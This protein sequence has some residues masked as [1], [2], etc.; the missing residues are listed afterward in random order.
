MNSHPKAR[1]GLAG[2]NALV[3]EIERG[4]SIRGA[5]RAFKVSP[6]TAHKWWHRRLR[7]EGL[8]DRSSRPH[9]SPRMLSAAAQE[10]ICEVRRNTGWG[11]RLVA[12]VVGRPHSTVHRTL[13]RH[14]ISRWSRPKREKAFRYEWPCP[15]DL[16]HM[17]TKRYARFSRPGHAVTG[18][19]FRSGAE[20]RAGVGY[21]WVH[22]IVDDHSRLAY[23]ELH[24]D[25]RAA[26]V[27]AFTRRALAFFEARGVRAKRL[28]TD[29][30]FAYTKS[31]ELRELLRA[32][33]IKHLLIQPRR[34]QTNGKVERFQ[35]TMA[36][37]WGYGLA[38][39]SSD[40]RARALSHWLR[41]YNESRPHSSIGDRP[42]ISRVHDLSR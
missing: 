13:Q 18:D 36:R 35:Q 15:G 40:H 32:R 24:P 12:G 42:P 21:E 16:L 20:K 33:E 28:M 41:Y 23:S 26:T 9:R 29:N 25:E 7:G 38:Y 1:L 4:S 14:G 11:P 5:A 22:S 39:R 8:R 31:S 6:A 37:E 27:V 19:R 34:P 2:R 17:D 10:R 3:S 30:A